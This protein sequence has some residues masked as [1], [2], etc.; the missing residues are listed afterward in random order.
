MTPVRRVATFRVDEDVLEG[1]EFLRDRDGI[2][3]SEQIRRGL[4][5]WLDSKGVKVKAAPRRAGT[6]RKA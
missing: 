5:L 1:M 2:P 6:R 4:R 3:F